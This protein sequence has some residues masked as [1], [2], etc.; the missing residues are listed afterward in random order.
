MDED[1]TGPD[2][3]ISCVALAGP[4]PEPT[5]DEFMTDLYPRVQESLKFLADEHVILEDPL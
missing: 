2:L 1:Q 3:G 5:Y 4:D